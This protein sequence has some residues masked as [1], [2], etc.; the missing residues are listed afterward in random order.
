MQWTPVQEAFANLVSRHGKLTRCEEQTNDDNPIFVFKT[1]AGDCIELDCIA[2][3]LRHALTS[4]A[5]FIEFVASHY[6][7]RK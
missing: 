4:T 7:M 6:C 5:T 2:V 1:Q 3:E